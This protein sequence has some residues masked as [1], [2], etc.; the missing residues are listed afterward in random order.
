MKVMQINSVYKYG[1]TGKIVFD[2]GDYLG[3]AGIESIICYGR[4]QKTTDPNVHKVSSEIESKIHSAMSRMTGIDF[5]YSTLATKRLIGLIIREKPDV[6]HL[7]CLNAHFVNVFKLLNFLK[8]S[9]IRTILTLHAEIMHTAGCEHAMQCDKWM[10][11]CHKCIKIKG[12]VSHLFRDDAKKCSELMKFAFSGF[13]NLTV[14][15]AS[16]WITERAKQSYIFRG[17]NCEYTFIH[18]GIDTDTFFRRDSNQIRSTLVIDDQKKVILHVTPDFRYPIK[19]GKYLLE[20]AKIMPNCLFIVVGIKIMDVTLPNNIIPI[21]FTKD[22]SELAEYY[23]LADCM[24]CTSLRENY[25]TVCVE[26]VSCGC[27]VVAFDSGGIKE[28]IPEQMGQCVE[29]YDLNK[30][31]T[32][33]THWMN[34]PVD[35]DFV[36]QIRHN[37]TV[38][39]MFEQ[40]LNLYMRK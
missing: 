27:K 14:V 31:K 22:K 11:G 20:L 3:K 16:E 26:A 7:H 1:S 30:M 39:H 18:N 37:N 36:E 25:P 2:I 8:T 34:R 6:V 32:A 21:A 5:G 38:K 19:G 33:I 4:G 24:A 40:Y 9:G 28:A 29:C 10:T 35:L 13:H 17:C 12:A 15:G 23:S